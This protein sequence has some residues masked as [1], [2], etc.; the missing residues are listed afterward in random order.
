MIATS[1]CAGVGVGMA[2]P[3]RRRDRAACRC[4]LFALRR[5]RKCREANACSPPVERVLRIVGLYDLLTDGVAV[6]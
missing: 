2:R 3:Q 5:T 4:G 1:C 6:A